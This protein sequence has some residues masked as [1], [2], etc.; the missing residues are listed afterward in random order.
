MAGC[1]W[2]APFGEVRVR[3]FRVEASYLRRHAAET[4]VV[5]VFGGVI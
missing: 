4:V 1:D 5:A 3:C 2:V